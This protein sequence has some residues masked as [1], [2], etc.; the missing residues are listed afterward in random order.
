MRK[1][2]ES[3]NPRSGRR[4]VRR[5][6]PGDDRMMNVEPRTEVDPYTQVISAEY[7]REKNTKDL[8]PKYPSMDTLLEQEGLEMSDLRKVREA[9]YDPQYH[10]DPHSAVYEIIETRETVKVQV[11]EIE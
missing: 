1:K 9:P 11:E 7:R 10:D 4:R 8:T 6:K 5:R 3:E 2:N